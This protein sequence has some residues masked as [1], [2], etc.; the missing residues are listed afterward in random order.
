MPVAG[1]LGLLY[2]LSEALIGHLRPAKAG[3]RSAADRSSTR[4]LW[5]LIPVSMFLG[6]EMAFGLRSAGWGYQPWIN[7]LGIAIT[8]A[9]LAFRWYSILYLGRFF[10]VNVEIAADHQ[11]IDS[12]PY[13]RLR[14]PSYTGALLAFYG[15]A[16]C[17]QNWASLAIMTVGPTAAFLYRIHVEEAALSGAFGERYRDYIQRTARLIPAVY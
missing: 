8:I 4:V 13:R 12:G 5:I 2:F 10:T 14:H 3:A 11:L 16:L 1:Y 7:V 6:F 9:G 15:L 17:T